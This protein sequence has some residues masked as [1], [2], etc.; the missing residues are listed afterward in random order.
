MNIGDLVRIHYPEKPFHRRTGTLI[1]RRRN[2]SMISNTIKLDKPLRFRGSDV[3]HYT[4]VVTSSRLRKRTGRRVGKPPTQKA[5][6][7]RAA[8]YDF[9]VAFKA[10]HNGNSPTYQEIMDEC[11]LPTKSVV[12]HYLNALEKD[13]VIKREW[14][15]QRMITV[16]G[17]T[18][19]APGEALI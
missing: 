3:E 1:E 8:I 13:G 7:R 15:E 9:I 16:V 14:S 19:T 5:I 12:S 18:W 17:S 10:A 4:V 6:M 11:E 2:G